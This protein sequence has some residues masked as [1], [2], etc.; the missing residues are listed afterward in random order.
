LRRVAKQ[1]SG[2]ELLRLLGDHEPL[3]LTGLGELLVCESGT[4]PSRLVDRVV[5]LSLVDRTTPDAGDRR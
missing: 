1:G 5:D 4:N 2:S 3:M